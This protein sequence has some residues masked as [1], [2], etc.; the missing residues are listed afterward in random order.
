[1][2]QFQK[3]ARNRCKIKMAI[4][5]PSGSGKT[6][7]ALL[8]AYGLTNNWDK[9]AVIDSENGSANLYSHLGSY[10]V[11]SL[12]PPYSPEEYIEAINLAVKNGYECLIIDSLSAE[13]NG[14]GGILDIH[15]NI[16]G[17]SFAAWS[18][19]TPRHNAFVQTIL[20]SDIHIIGTMRSK[21]EYV[22][23]DKNGKQ[24]P[25]KVGLKPVQRED[26]EY[27]FT[28][29]LELSQKHQ[30]TIGKDR[31]G[32]FRNRPELALNAE[33]GKEIAQ[34]CNS[35]KEESITTQQKPLESL[36]LEKE[37]DELQDEFEL[38]INACVT[39]EKLTELFNNNPNQQRK[40]RSSFVLRKNQ[41][42]VL[43]KTFLSNG[44]H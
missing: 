17:N 5:G 28:L 41:I 12:K 10:S 7:S 44:V 42:D 38:Q 29:V 24:V 2:K 4:Q 19:V 11:L 36:P 8:V 26:S 27:E 15:S 23:A 40:Y 33:V 1:M 32:L 31:T 34:W 39:I 22:M 6:Y 37:P 30:A 9:I 14:Q 25:E 13:W 16:P 21:T 18:K 20:Q 3:A 35:V 43:P